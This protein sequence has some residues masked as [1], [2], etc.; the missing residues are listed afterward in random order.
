MHG[1]GH[2]SGAVVAVDECLHQFVHGH[3]E[4]VERLVGILLQFI[5]QTPH[6]H[7]RRVTVTLHPFGNVLLP[8]LFKRNLPTRV[9]TRPFVVEFIHHKDTIFVAELNK[10]TAVG[11][12]TGSYM[13]NAPFFHHLDTFFYSPWIGG[14]TES[15]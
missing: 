14:C 15:S 1:H 2:Q 6:H 10:L 11:I 7:R 13:V 8:Q 4:V 9:L 12:M 5:A 3:T